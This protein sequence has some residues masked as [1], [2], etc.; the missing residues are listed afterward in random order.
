M[1]LN[2]CQIRGFAAVS[3]V[4]DSQSVAKDVFI[5]EVGPQRSLNMSSEYRV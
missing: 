4:S 2:G 3:N 1:S 5:L